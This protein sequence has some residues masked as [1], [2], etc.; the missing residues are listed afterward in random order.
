MDISKNDN[1]FEKRTYFGY[2]NE[3]LLCYFFRSCLIYFRPFLW[4]KSFLWLQI[5]LFSRN[6]TSSP[7]HWL[8]HRRSCPVKNSFSKPILHIHKRVCQSFWK[9]P[10]LPFKNYFWLSLT[11][12]DL[13][14]LVILTDFGCGHE[15]WPILEKN[16]LLEA[17]K[18]F[19]VTRMVGNK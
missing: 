19:C 13:N 9:W 18:S 15:K 2:R 5:N 10:A 11:S 4:H 12:G 14:D 3:F 6:W 17:I 1:G 7:G 8:G 16:G